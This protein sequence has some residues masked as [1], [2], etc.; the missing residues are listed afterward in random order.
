MTGQ[1]VAVAL[2]AGGS[3][4]RFKS[5]VPKAFLEVAS[6]PLIHHSLVAFDAMP[7][8]AS[9]RIAV[10]AGEG[11][12]LE[13]ALEALKL[14][15]YGGWVT[16]GAERPDSALA[17]LRALEADGPD[18][19]LIHDAARP[20]VSAP[21]V[22]DLLKAL[23]S[24]DGAFLAAPAVDTL[25]R[26]HG[27][28]AVGTVDRTGLVRALTPQAFRYPVIREAYER[29]VSEGFP[30]TDDASFASKAGAD[31]VWVQGSPRNLKVTYPEDLALAER[32]LRGEA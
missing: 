24:H 31:V 5:P 16:G 14:R 9:I 6:R 7:E 1:K 13:A 32:L 22:R 15:A 8:V 25:W 20:V 27:D 12:R 18:L 19:V 30:G 23:E 28:K 10:P 3:G 2:L 4:I 26:I 21:E 11:P 29:G 17:A